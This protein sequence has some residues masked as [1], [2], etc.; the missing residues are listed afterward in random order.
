MQIILMS[1]VNG[2]ALSVFSV[3]SDFC[4]R[5][6]EHGV[7]WGHVGHYQGRPPGEGPTRVSGH[8]RLQ[9]P[10]GKQLSVQHRPHVQ[11]S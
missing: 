4:W 8:P 6:E 3:R 7:C 10:S 9:N 2:V 1:F 5:P 11:V